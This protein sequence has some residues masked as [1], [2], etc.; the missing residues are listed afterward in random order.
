[1]DERRL[2]F[3]YLHERLDDV[4]A[5]L[6]PGRIAL[7]P[8]QHKIIVHDR[9]TLHAVTLCYELLFLGLRVDEHDVRITT[10]AGVERLTRPLRHDLDLDARLALELG[11][12]EI[13][14][15]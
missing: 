12:N 11:Q 3:L 5:A 10:T 1:R 13:E 8:D 4:L 9:V 2:F 6:D 15:T 14:Q 7:R